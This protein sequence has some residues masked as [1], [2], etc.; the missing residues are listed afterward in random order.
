MPERPLEAH[1]VATR[2]DQPGRVEMAK[3]VQPHPAHS[4][5]GQ[6]RAPSVADGV[7]VG[8]KLGVAFEQPLVG[9]AERHVLSEHVDERLGGV[10]R[11][12]GRR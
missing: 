11:S 10:D 7:L 2:G 9:Q 1:H 4:G 8:R 5:P 3:V 12:F 6:G